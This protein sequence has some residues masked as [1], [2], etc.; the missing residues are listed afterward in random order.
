[1]TELVMCYL[2]Y[3]VTYRVSI[4]SSPSP[5]LRLFLI[6]QARHACSVCKFLCEILH[7]R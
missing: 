2:I 6:F 1:M 4:N 7:S 3:K 5:T